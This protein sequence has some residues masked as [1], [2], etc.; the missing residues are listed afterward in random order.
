M[1]D[2]RV[3]FPVEGSL[4][5][6]ANN[7]AGIRRRLQ[8]RNVGVGDLLVVTN[9]YRPGSYADREGEPMDV[10]V[11]G[12]RFLVNADAV[13]V[14]EGVEDCGSEIVFSVV[15]YP[16]GVGYRIVVRDVVGYAL[17][18]AV[19]VGVDG[20]FYYSPFGSVVGKRFVH[21]LN[22]TCVGKALPA[23]A[24]HLQDA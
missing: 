7:V 1:L 15:E 5:P 8:E 21:G 18:D 11:F 13:F 2:D 24:M 10:F 12:R 20:A 6:D 3:L 22:H 9:P 14:V 4:E 19:I 23:K 17:A 16:C